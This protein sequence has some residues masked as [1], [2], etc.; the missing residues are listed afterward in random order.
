MRI[1][2]T[3]E[4]L[5]DIVKISNTLNQVLSYIKM[6]KGGG[7]Y[8]IL[9][10]KLIK[11]N[12]D[13]SHFL[14]RKEICEKAIVNYKIPLDKIL[15]KNSTFNHGN[16]LK[17]KLYENGLKKKECEECGQGEEWRGKKISLILDHIDG[18]HYN[19]EI[20][21]LRI[22][23]PNCNAATDTFCRGKRFKNKLLP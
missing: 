7:N 18:D 13:T 16:N 12:I 17:N 21:N 2:I 15:I 10:R 3:K 20:I 14:T 6:N 1:K 19:N 4:E 9:R 22:L 5:E 8:Q 23:C 11:W